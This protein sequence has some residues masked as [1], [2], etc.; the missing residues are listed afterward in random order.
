MAERPKAPAM[1]PDNL[2]LISMFLIME[3]KNW[4]SMAS[5][6]APWH[7]CLQTC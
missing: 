7:I 6:Y 1:K 4:L 2:N 3:G 5:A